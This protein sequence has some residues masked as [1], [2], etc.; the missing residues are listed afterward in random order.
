MTRILATLNVYLVPRHSIIELNSLN[1]RVKN[2]LNHNSL[3]MK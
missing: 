2:L 3:F 1:K